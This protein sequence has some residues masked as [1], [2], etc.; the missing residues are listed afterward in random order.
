MIDSSNV[1]I[2]ININVNS[3]NNK[4]AIRQNKALFHGLKHKCIFLIARTE[5][6]EH[7]NDFCIFAHNEH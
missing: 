1:N 2:N 6:I 5:L 7:F 4:T 3:N